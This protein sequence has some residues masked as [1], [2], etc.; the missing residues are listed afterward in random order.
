MKTWPG[1]ELNFISRF[2]SN[3]FILVI[4]AP[5]INKLNKFGIWSVN[6][7][8]IYVCWTSSVFNYLWS[9]ISIVANAEDAHNNACNFLRG[10]IF[11]R[12]ISLYSVIK[13]I[14]LVANFDLNRSIEDLKKLRPV[15]LNKFISLI[16]YNNKTGLSSNSISFL[17]NLYLYKCPKL[18]ARF[19]KY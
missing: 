14:K 3:R 17:S 4:F 19:R 1:P 6:K 2:T 8:F 10:I 16:Y 13:S 15:H 9:L 7:C 11:N 5:P 18:A 12:W